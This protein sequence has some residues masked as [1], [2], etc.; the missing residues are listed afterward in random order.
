MG[1][2][3]FSV[4]LQFFA[5]LQKDFG[6]EQTLVFKHPISLYQ[7][8]EKLSIKTGVQALD[9]FLERNR[10]TLKDEYRILVDGTNVHGLKG[11]RTV[12][13]KDCEVAFF[14][15]I[16]GGATSIKSKSWKKNYKYT[17]IVNFYWSA[18]FRKPLSIRSKSVATTMFFDM[19]SKYSNNAINNRDK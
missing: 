4:K 5:F 8:L 17:L 6:W 19:S 16:A 9:I 7:L 1:N 12:I 15:A 11:I 3:E 18:W 14:P 10:T 13:E 2:L